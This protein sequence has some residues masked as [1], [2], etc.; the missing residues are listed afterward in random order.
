MLC[1][2]KKRKGTTVSSNALN[3]HV[4]GEILS[5][6]KKLQNTINSM[7]LLLFAIFDKV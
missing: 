6:G 1:S 4:S 5:L 7:Y 3:D 2:S